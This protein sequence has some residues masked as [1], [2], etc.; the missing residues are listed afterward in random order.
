MGRRISVLWGEVFYVGT[1]RLHNFGYE[2]A[3]MELDTKIN[4]ITTGPHVFADTCKVL[5][6]GGGVL[7]GM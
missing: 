7:H 6:G 1:K 3:I 4:M 5:A 2:Y